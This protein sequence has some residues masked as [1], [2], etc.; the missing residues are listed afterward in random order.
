MAPGAH[1]Q[2]ACYPINLQERLG[3]HVMAIERW[4]A[5]SVVDHTSAKKLAAEVILYDRLLLPKPADRDRDRWKTNKW[6]AEGMIARIDQLGE[7]AIGVKWDLDRR[8]EWE[9]HMKELGEDA[10]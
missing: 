6:D 7:I 1:P 2:Q 5:F 10:E 4:G 8:K 3:R 9:T